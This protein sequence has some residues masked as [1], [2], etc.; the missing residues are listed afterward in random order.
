MFSAR[1]EDGP[2]QVPKQESRNLTLATMKN[3]GKE[4][5]QCK[6]TLTDRS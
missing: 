4:K 1:L 5:R 6:K 2:L 3:I